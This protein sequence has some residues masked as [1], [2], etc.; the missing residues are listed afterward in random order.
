MPRKPLAVV[1]VLVTGGLVWFYTSAQYI[2]WDGGF[3]LTVHVTSS[4]GPLRSVTC[5]AYGQRD[6]AEQAAKYLL[7]PESDLW[8]A[9]ADPFTGEPLTLNIPLSGRDSMSGR[10]LS[11]FQF[12]HLVV[13][14]QLQDGRRVSK[15]VEIPDCRVSRDV[16]VALP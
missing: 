8:A 4:A 16:S 15:L 11:R 10:E 13:I 9:Q 5:R 6:D 12:R 14:G 2:I 1:L 3:D 7:P